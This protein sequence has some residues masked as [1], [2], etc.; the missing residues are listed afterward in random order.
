ML[1][2]HVSFVAALCLELFVATEGRALNNGR[3]RGGAIG[4]LL[5][6]DTFETCS[7]IAVDCF[8]K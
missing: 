4:K 1:F 7:G 8:G 2:C 6:G 3:F 5:D